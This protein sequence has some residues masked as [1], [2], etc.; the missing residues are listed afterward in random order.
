M[1]KILKAESPRTNQT[2]WKEFLDPGFNNI[3]AL[4]ED[5]LGVSGYT[6]ILLY[7]VT[8]V[9][10]HLEEAP[11]CMCGGHSALLSS[12]HLGTR[13]WRGEALY[14]CSSL[15]NVTRTV[16]KAK[17]GGFTANRS[18]PACWFCLSLLPPPALAIPPGQRRPSRPTPPPPIHQLLATSATSTCTWV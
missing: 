16:G 10:V 14:V 8:E 15:H 11:V 13:C 2:G 5:V 7:N 3:E 17:G 4:P 6:K 18:L 9:P 12:H 1:D